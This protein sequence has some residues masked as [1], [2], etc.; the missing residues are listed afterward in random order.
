MYI[1][2]AIGYKM[3]TEQPLYYSENCFGTTDAISFRK[4][5]L[6]IHDF[7]SGESPTSMRQLEV[8]TALFCLEYGINPNTIEVIE[9][10]IYQKDEVLVHNPIREDILYIMEKIVTF[11]KRLE[12]EKLED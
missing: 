11:D 7:K 10:R 5:I 1:N 9:L 8:Y 6:R 4:N 12:K 2:D 3:T